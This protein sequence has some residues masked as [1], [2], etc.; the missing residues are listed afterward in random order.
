MSSNKI[1]LSFSVAFA[2]GL[3]LSSSLHVTRAAPLDLSHTPLFLK[4]GVAP[5]LILTLDDSGSMDRDYVPD[6]LGADDN[7]LA[8]HSYR[9]NGMAYNPQVTYKPPVD[10]N[11][12]PLSTRF[13]DA[14]DDGFV[15]T[16]RTDLR[17]RYPQPGWSRGPAF[18]SVWDASNAGCNGTPSD[19]D[20]YDKV[21][22][23]PDQRQNFADWYSF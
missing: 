19:N 9:F 18:Y 13:E 2:A 20:C 22:V 15:R 16:S 5:N 14:W 11:G 21:V 17:S 10:A 1:K 23:P 8:F 4:T 6:G 3:V 7:D 12:T